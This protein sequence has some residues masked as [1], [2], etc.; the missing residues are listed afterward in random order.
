[1]MVMYG[2]NQQSRVII[3]IAQIEIITMVHPIDVG[4]VIC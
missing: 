1:M 4:A 2:N 3:D